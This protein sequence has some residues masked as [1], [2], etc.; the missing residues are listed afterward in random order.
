MSVNAGNAATVAI[1][2]RNA[3]SFMMKS[4]VPTCS[5]FWSFDFKWK[6]F[7]ESI[8]P[9]DAVVY[10]DGSGEYRPAP[11]WIIWQLEIRRL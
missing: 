11:Y 6:H 5:E 10:L 7:I 8:L 1:S 2:D 9:L 4:Q 3:V